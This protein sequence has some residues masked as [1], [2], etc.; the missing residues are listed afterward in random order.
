MFLLK[1]M[2]VRLEFEYKILFR[3]YLHTDLPCVNVFDFSLSYIVTHLFQMYLIGGQLSS[4][5]NNS[6]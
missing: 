1:N 4:L 6:W 5:S 2:N 3:V